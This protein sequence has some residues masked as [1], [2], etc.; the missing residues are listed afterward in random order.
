MVRISM[1]TIRWMSWPLVSL[2]MVA[3]VGFFL[4]QGYAGPSTGAG[5]MPW[6]SSRPSSVSGTGSEVEIGGYSDE[7]P[8]LSKLVDEKGN[9]ISDVQ[10]LLDFAIVGH[11]K[12]ATTALMKW[13]ASHDEVQMYTREIHS[14]FK[15]KPDE[16]VELM[17]ALP[18]G[19]QYKRGYK[20]PT[21]VQSLMSLN[22][23]RQYWG[24]TKLI[25]GVRCVRS[26]DTWVDQEFIFDHAITICANCCFFS[27]SKIYL[28]IDTP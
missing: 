5:L 11:P 24:K 27:A 19:R 26:D 13:L 25:V 9:I 23:L 18:E 17:Y 22:L 8:P 15:G 12:T 7:R 20:L 6:I 10:F 2:F 1:A 16:L 28:Y 21:D 4:F 14:L 3:S